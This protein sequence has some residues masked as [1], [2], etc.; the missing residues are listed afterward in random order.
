MSNV[1]FCKNQNRRKSK[2]SYVTVIYVKLNSVPKE[3][4]KTTTDGSTRK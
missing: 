3:K 1:K 2:E 4:V